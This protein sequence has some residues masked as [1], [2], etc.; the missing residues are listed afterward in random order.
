MG[1]SGLI[2]PKP[3]QPEAQTLEEGP[4][5]RKPSQRYV[6]HNT[7]Q[8]SKN[9]ISEGVSCVQTSSPQ[10]KFEREGF[11]DNYAGF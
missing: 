7:K 8:P 11:G 4:G 6:I 2:I 10:P 5:L 1:A 3:S 9:P